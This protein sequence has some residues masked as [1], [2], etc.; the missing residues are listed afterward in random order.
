MK[1]EKFISYSQQFEDLILWNV[2]KNEKNGFYVDIGANDPIDCSVTKS[3]YERG[4]NGINIEPLE[5]E[6][7]ELCKDRG[8]DL[9]ICVGIGKEEKEMSL[10][11]CGQLSTFCEKEKMVLKRKIKGRGK[12]CLERKVKIMTFSKIFKENKSFIKNVHFMK[13]DVEGS[14]KDVLDGIDFSEIRPWIFIIESTRPGTMLST[15]E[16]FEKILLE[17][18]YIFCKQIGV[19]RYYVAC[20]KTYLKDRFISIDELLKL[21]DVFVVKRYEEIKF[22]KYYI[23]LKRLSKKIFPNFI[24]DNWMKFKNNKSEFYS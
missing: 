24:V 8:K 2:L 12:E 10:L 9:N 23:N 3:F 14:E 17:N 7:K 1:R 19:N 20:E 22:I 16:I 18:N 5:E 13:I 15:T 21:Y 6:Y 4:W 11:V